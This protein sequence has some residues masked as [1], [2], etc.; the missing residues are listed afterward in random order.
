[1]WQFEKD[2]AAI[3]DYTVDWSKW[4]DA[5]TI[6]TSQWTVST[7]LAQVSSSNDLKSATAWLSGGSA[8]QAYTATNRITTSGGRTDERS[9]I[10]N[11]KD[12]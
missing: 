3:L 2:P 10:I 11:V 7:G 1:M 5:D 4:L 12:R 6:I 9:I 8:G